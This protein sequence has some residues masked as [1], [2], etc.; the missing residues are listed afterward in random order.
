MKIHFQIFSLKVLLL[1]I[2]CGLADGQAS[3][4][5]KK[6]IG[7]KPK[8]TSSLFKAFEDCAGAKLVFDRK[9]LPPGNY[10]EKLPVLEAGKKKKAVEILMEE[11]K[12]YP[13][14]YLDGS[15]PMR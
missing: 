12:K 10:H 2:L 15:P 13:P 5:D 7:Q 9:D 4:E 6:T 14:G 8:D 3:A 1:A 11:V